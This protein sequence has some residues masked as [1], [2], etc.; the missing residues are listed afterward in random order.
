M[1]GPSLHRHTSGVNVMQT[2]NQQVHLEEGI[3][4]NGT[5]GSWAWRDE[6]DSLSSPKGPGP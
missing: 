1:I 4:S 5:E 3:D 2:F 6:R